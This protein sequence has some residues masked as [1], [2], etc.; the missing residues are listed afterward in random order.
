MSMSKS[1]ASIHFATVDS[2]MRVAG[3]SGKTGLVFPMPHIT[4]RR[5][6]K[7]HILCKIDGMNVA[8]ILDT[9]Q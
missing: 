3:S 7:L 8:S 1:C 9:A 2:A 6:G 5:N 4:T